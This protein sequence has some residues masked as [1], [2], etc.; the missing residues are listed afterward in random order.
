MPRLG[1][2]RCALAAWSVLLLAVPMSA[3]AASPPAQIAP[4]DA[5][6]FPTGTAVTMIVQASAGQAVYVTVS[7]DPSQYPDGTMKGTAVQMEPEASDPSR[8]DYTVQGP[9][10]PAT[11]YWQARVSDTGCATGCTPANSPVR[12]FSWQTPPPQD[13]EASPVSPQDNA[14]VTY[15][16]KR[17]VFAWT[18][19]GAWFDDWLE[20]FAQPPATGGQ[21]V[22]VHGL[23]DDEYRQSGVA[24][25]PGLNKAIIPVQLPPGRYFWRVVND[26]R[27]DTGRPRATP[28]FSFSIAPPKVTAPPTLNVASQYGYSRRR[29]GLTLATLTA[30]PYTHLALTIK[31]GARTIERAVWAMGSS[32][33]VSYRYPWRCAR[34]GKTRLV[35][36]VRDDYGNTRT[37]S[38]LVRIPTCSQ[39]LAREQRLQAAYEERARAFARR[40][41]QSGGRVS[42]TD[43]EDHCLR[44][45]VIIIVLLIP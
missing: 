31:R 6:A 25:D 12:S 32:R 13:P 33:T 21:P 45:S 17:I 37:T 40:C 20:F 38:D 29:P 2:K 23:T 19:A 42:H 16:P 3:I 27:F 1:I 43:G 35:A 26:G 34:A 18:K 30:P 44:R 28:L 8:Y 7:G 24:V 14:T 5:A 9:S 15:G 41:R 36:V 39:V 4:G 11:L 22:R 10:Q